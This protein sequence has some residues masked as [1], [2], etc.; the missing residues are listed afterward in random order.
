[1]GRATRHASHLANEEKG[2]NHPPRTPTP[3][4]IAF[5]PLQPLL[6]PPSCDL[7]AFAAGPGV[8][9]R[10]PTD[11]PTALRPGAAARAVVAS[12]PTLRV[13]NRVTNSGVSPA[14]G[15]GPPKRPPF[16][17]LFTTLRSPSGKSHWRSLTP[18]LSIACQNK[19]SG[20]Q[21][22]LPT[23]TRL[24]GVL[25]RPSAAPP[26]TSLFTTRLLSLNATLL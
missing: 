23:A 7:A 20:L 15:E 8:G 22:N 1:M 26:L 25:G 10:L 6:Q 5:A 3:T 24:R 12:A 18:S 21:T 16:I 2:T 19:G 17:T 9:S 4:T 14:S 11:S 13:A